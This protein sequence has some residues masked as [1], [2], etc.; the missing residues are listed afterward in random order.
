MRQIALQVS[1]YPLLKY[2]DPT[3]SQVQVLRFV[4]QVLCLFQRNVCFEIFW[5]I[6]VMPSAL[7]LNRGVISLSVVYWLLSYYYDETP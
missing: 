6:T 2:F 3:M 5:A 1:I 4:A 7:F